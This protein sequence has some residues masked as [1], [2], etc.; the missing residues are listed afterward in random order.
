MLR[1]L[2]GFGKSF[3]NR[4]DASPHLVG[5]QLPSSSAAQGRPCFLN[6]APSTISF[7]ALKQL[8]DGAQPMQARAAVHPSVPWWPRVASFFRAL[9]CLQG[10]CCCSISSRAGLSRV[11][12]SDSSSTILADQCRQ[13]SDA[14]LSKAMAHHCGDWSFLA[15]HVRMCMRIAHKRYEA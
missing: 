11:N 12:E 10:F 8:V 4:E 15:H 2:Q 13:A 7:T 14:Q 9:R 5:V 1:C 6:S 3:L